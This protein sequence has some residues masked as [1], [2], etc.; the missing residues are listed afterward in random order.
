MCYELC[1]GC[2]GC[3]D[4][5]WYKIK[6][7]TGLGLLWVGTFVLGCI[8]I[9]YVP[10]AWYDKRAKGWWNNRPCTVEGY[11]ITNDDP[12]RRRLSSGDDST[13]DGDI[14]YYAVLQVEVNP[15][16]DDESYH[17]TAVKFPSWASGT[18]SSTLHGWDNK[19]DAKHWAKGFNKDAYYTCWKHPGSKSSV[20]ISNPGY[21]Y[22]WQVGI[23][24]AALTLTA[25]PILGL[26]VFA[27]VMYYILVIKPQRAH[28]REAMRIGKKQ[29]QGDSRLELAMV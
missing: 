15:D 13:D 24:I 2:F 22:N 20:A 17:T 16:D 18:G 28:R 12:N 1:E 19:K 10:L 26:V 11:Y 29:A 14:Y 5:T 4:E 27:A 9:L 8:Y 3:D 7:Y 23:G 21:H 6:L 25:A